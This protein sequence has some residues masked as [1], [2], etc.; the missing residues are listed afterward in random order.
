MLFLLLMLS[1]LFVAYHMGI[2]KGRK[3]D[4][5]QDHQEASIVTRI[6]ERR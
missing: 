3:R 6:R 2:E 1:L 4:A 5:Q